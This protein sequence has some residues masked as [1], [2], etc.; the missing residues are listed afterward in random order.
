MKKVFNTSVVSL[1]I[2]SIILLTSCGSANLN[3]TQKGAGLGAVVGGVLG[4]VIGNNVGDKNNS[5]LGVILGATIGGVV[6]GVI[7]NKM[8]RNAREIEAALP[9][10]S[11]ERV[12]EG[13]KVTL[14]EN[15]VLFNTNQDRLTSGAK[16][17]LDRIITVFKQYPD[18]NI[19]VIGYT[20]S[21]GSYEYNL[22][23]SKKRAKSVIA[24]LTERNIKYG[25]LSSEGK[26]E[27]EPIG[28]NE[29]EEGR[30]LNRRV[31]FAI[32]ANEKMIE[33][34]QREIEN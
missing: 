13:I 21:R 10:A 28:S 19:K 25:R 15:S 6:G 32:T 18:T 30:M 26:G 12:G 2:Y 7:G 5:T 4:G 23:L 27:T 16:N 11:V 8:D 17:N 20:D 3:K 22:E 9:G 24:Y 1:L 29:T 34:A 31:E 33:D 14:G